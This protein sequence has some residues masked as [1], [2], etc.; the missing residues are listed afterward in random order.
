MT[1]PAKI[2]KDP[3]PRHA[4]NQAHKKALDMYVRQ[5]LSE[6]A[7]LGDIAK[8]LEIGEK[9]LRRWHAPAGEKRDALYSD[10]RRAFAAKL[11]GVGCNNEQIAELMGISVDALKKNMQKDLSAGRAQAGARVKET[12][13]QMATSGN[14]PHT[15]IFWLKAREGWRDKDEAPATQVQVAT[16]GPIEVTLGGRRLE[17]SADGTSKLIDE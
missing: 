16:S 12:L 6:N 13:F 17:S 1:K 5:R 15:T 9:T 2:K 8:E 7:E 3:L 14:Q 10:E 4:R 11:A